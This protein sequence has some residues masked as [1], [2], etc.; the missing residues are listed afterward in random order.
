MID[1]KNE[2]QDQEKTRFKKWLGGTEYLERT[3]TLWLGGQTLLLAEAMAA[4]RREGIDDLVTRLIWH[5]YTRRAAAS[6]AYWKRV[7]RQKNEGRHG[8]ERNRA[9]T[10]TSHLRLLERPGSGTNG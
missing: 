1:N 5:E 6:A 2:D 8:H 7:N 10:G 3:E 4:T 9:G